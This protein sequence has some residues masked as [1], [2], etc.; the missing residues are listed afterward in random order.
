MLW[1]IELNLIDE[2]D[3]LNSTEFFIFFALIKYNPWACIENI[4]TADNVGKINN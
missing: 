2:N 3:T 4:Y 1:K